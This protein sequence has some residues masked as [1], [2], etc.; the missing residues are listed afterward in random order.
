MNMPPA[1]EHPEVVAAYLEEELA[2]GRLVVLEVG[3]AESLGIHA[4]PFGVI[5][6]KSKP[7]LKWRLILDTIIL[8]YTHRGH[9]HTTP[10]A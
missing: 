5:P 3:T 7:N 9:N 1:E 2:Q 6:K 4:S 8:Y 10:Y